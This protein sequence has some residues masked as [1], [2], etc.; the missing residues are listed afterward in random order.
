MGSINDLFTQKQEV[1]IARVTGFSSSKEFKVSIGGTIRRVNSAASEIIKVGDT[2]LLNKTPHGK[3]YIVG[4]TTG[5]GNS[6]NVKE[7]TRNG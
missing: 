2:V 3:Y 1:R 4:K 5:L 7:I 6:K